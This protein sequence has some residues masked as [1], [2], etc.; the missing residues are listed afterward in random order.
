VAAAG[1]GTTAKAILSIW[2]NSVLVGLRRR[3]SIL[4]DACVEI[5]P[6]NPVPGA[7]IP[8]STETVSPLKSTS[9]DP[10][11]AA[12]AKLAPQALIEE[13]KRKV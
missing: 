10:A 5:N 11:L 7:P 4:S 6:T 1:S 12:E 13:E 8:S 9:K 2:K 3:K